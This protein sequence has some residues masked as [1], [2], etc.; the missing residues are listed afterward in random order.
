MNSATI[1][2]CRMAIAVVILF[3]VILFFDRSLLRIRLKD[4]WLFAGGGIL[5]TLGLNL[6]YNEA[7]NRLTLSLAAVLLSLAPIFVLLLAAV[8]FREKITGKKVGCML[9]AILGCAFVSGIFEAS[10][11]L[12]WSAAGIAIGIA[13]AFFYAFYSIFSKLSM[14]HGYHP[15]TVT[16][17]CLLLITIVL[18]PLTDWP[19]VGDFVGLSPVK[20]T[21]FL[22]LHSLCAYVMPYILYTVSLSHIEAGKAS[23]LASGEPVAAMVFGLFF[24]DEIPTALSVLGLVLTIT[25]LTL[26][27]LPDRRLSVHSHRQDKS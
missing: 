17:Y 12:T 19:V 27:S 10:S 22:L 18:I 20:N 25:A 2:T 7:I 9:L 26:L 11:S 15:L 6:C 14:E 5:G 16:F 4:I 24:Y 23:I 3:F 13:S 1:L 21:G 8:L